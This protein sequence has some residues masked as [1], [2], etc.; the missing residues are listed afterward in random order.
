VCLKIQIKLQ[1]ALQAGLMQLCRKILQIPADFRIIVGGKNQFSNEEFS[2][3]RGV[4]NS[5]K[6]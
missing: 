3:F 6:T 2:G 1:S 4:G 5:I